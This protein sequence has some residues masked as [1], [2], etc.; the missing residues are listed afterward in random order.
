MK[1]RFFA[2]CFFSLFLFFTPLLTHTKT[3]W[4]LIHGTFAQNAVWYQ[5]GGDFYESL[6]KE[7]PPAAKLTSFSWSGKNTDAAR[8]LAA[9]QLVHFIFNN[10]NW[11]DVINVI[12]H[13]HGGNIAILAAQLLAQ[14]FPYYKFFQLFGLAVPVAR[15]CYNANMNQIIF[16]YNF[17]SYGDSI[18]TIIQG[19]L[20]TY[21]AHER[22]WNIQL[23]Q[24]GMCPTHC[25][26]HPIELAHCLVN[27]TKYTLE[28][29][30]T[31]L[32]LFSHKPAYAD[33]DPNR[34]WD[35]KQDKMFT[36]QAIEHIG[37]YGL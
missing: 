20:R 6:K 31:V 17:F 23:T 25:S 10:Y 7:L 34:E 26:M 4:I 15:S 21:P 19:F 2:N 37:H 33:I 3:V 14:Q 9:Q 12:G 8:Q 11:D 16:L 24:N 28:N 30:A 18:Q 27:I 5:K 13:S 36:E 29:E 35:L 32:H 22:I 1:L